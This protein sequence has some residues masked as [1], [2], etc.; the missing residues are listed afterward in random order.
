MV[1]VG[2]H[3]FHNECVPPTQT[4]AF[5]AEFVFPG[6]VASVPAARDRVM[7]WLG[8]FRGSEDDELDLLIALQEA[9]ANAA[10]HG[11]NGD[12]GKQVRCLVEA[13]DETITVVVRDPG[14]GFDFASL[15]DPGK[16]QISKFYHGRGI[17]LMRSLVDEVCFAR[18]GAEIRLT[19]RIAKA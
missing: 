8:Q 16:Y 7:A 19:K 9:F 4:Q 6:D 15:A 2:R 18:G 17:A 10:L 13:D 3:N 5:R 1:V 12:P 11:C 14:P